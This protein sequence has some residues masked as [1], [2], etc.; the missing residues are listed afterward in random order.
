M[1]LSLKKGGNLSLSK[2]EPGLTKILIGLGWT[3]RATA[4]T[5]FDLDATCFVLAAT[6][7]VRSDADMIF[8]NQKESEDGTIRHMGD[9]RTG[10][11]DGDDEVIAVDLARVAADVQRL[12][13]CVTIHEADER[14]QNFGMVGEA[15][16]RVVNAETK[17]EIARYDLSEDASV[18]T[19]MIFGEVYRHDGEWKF[20]AVGQGFAGGL[21]ALAG[22]FGVDV[23]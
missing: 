16:V 6:G 7:K 2:A 11:G 23:G 21:G 13:A 5:E 3:P 9:N 14:R 20:K 12:V 10:V 17:R 22:N 4:G 8:Y 19:A 18:E 1:S 15:Y